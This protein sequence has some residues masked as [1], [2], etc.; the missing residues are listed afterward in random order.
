MISKIGDKNISSQF[1]ANR[2]TASALTLPNQKKTSNTKSGTTEKIDH[3]VVTTVSSTAKK[4]LQLNK[5]TNKA[6]NF[7]KEKRPT[8]L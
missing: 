5:T 2:K 8:D 1:P 7:I 6:N 3:S 4:A